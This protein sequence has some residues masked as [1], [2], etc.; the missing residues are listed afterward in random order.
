MPD[1]TQPTAMAIVYE[2][3]A[4]GQSDDENSK[5]AAMLARYYAP[6]TKLARN[7]DSPGQQAHSLSSRHAGRHFAQSG[8][9][10]KTS[11]AGLHE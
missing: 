7:L 2:G 6:S 3:V 11:A 8:D 5:L 1:D 9:G 4:I 10:T